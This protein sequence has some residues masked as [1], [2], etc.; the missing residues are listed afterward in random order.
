MS[1]FASSANDAAAAGSLV[2]TAC[3][4]ARIAL[5]VVRA[6]VEVAL[7]T[8]Q[9][10]VS[11]DT[12][13][14]WPAVGGQLPRGFP[15]ARAQIADGMT[16]RAPA[17]YPPGACDRLV[18]GV[19]N[20][21]LTWW[22]WLA[23][24]GRSPPGRSERHS[25]AALS[26][27]YRGCDHISLSNAARVARGS[28][29]CPYSQNKDCRHARAGHRRPPGRADRRGHGLRPPELLARHARGA[30]PP[31][32]RGPGRRRR[33]RTSGVVMFDLQGPKIRLDGTVRERTLCEGEEVLLIV[34]GEAG[35]TTRTRSR[36]PM[37]ICPSCSRSAPRWS[38][39]TARHAWQCW[40]WMGG[41]CGRS[42]ASRERCRRARA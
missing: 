4:R 6:V 3:A 22:L 25:G 33:G 5:E 42:L 12:G 29:R 18:T 31:L 34:A 16:R 32:R 7:A 17:R 1:S 39:A 27:R 40:R 8:A 41:A 14:P 10:Y 15:A 9:D 37:T 19:P 11:E 35:A 26:H 23:W 20:D 21:G 13:E 28:A 2:W 30:A 38:S 24:G 36:S